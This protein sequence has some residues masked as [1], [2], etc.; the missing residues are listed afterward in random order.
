MGQG[1]GG[2]LSRGR[3][4]RIAYTAMLRRS[5]RYN[6]RANAVRGVTVAVVL[7]AALADGHPLAAALCLPAVACCA[8]QLVAQR[9]QQRETLSGLRLVAAH[10]RSTARTS[11]RQRLAPASYVE[12]LAGLVLVAVP[13][14]LVAGAASEL[15]VLMLAAAVLHLASSSLAIFTDHSWYNP[16]EADPPGWQEM[17]RLLAGPLTAGVVCAVALPAP[18]PREAWLA[19]VAVC[20]GPLLLTLRIRNSDLTVESLSGL[21]REESQAGRDLV[22]NEAHGALSTHLRLL[23]Q[24]AR[25][26]RRSAPRLYELAVGANARLRETLTRARMGEDSLSGTTALAAPVL[27]LARAVGAEVAVDV[28]VDRLSGVDHELVRLVLNDLAGNAVNAGAGSIAVRVTRMGPDL[29]IEVRDDAPP[30]PARVWKSAGTSSARLERQLGEL[31][32]ALTCRE[33]DGGGGGKVIE[34][35]WVERAGPAGVGDGDGERAAG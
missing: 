26:V 15:R 30:M 28:A 3:R 35:R 32:G 29:V 14:W 7:V 17:G 6:A 2:R 22:V 33:E 31:S 5:S 10:Q 20:L 27:T 16:E 13:A 11:G 1:L 34:A 25:R 9:H 12:V 18:W 4:D 21:V 23:E 8:L 24:E 19:A